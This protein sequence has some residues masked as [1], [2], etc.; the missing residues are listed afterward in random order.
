VKTR[1]YFTIEYVPEGPDDP[2][3]E[4]AVIE[5][6]D[7]SIEQSRPVHAEYDVSG[8]VTRLV[9]DPVTTTKIVGK[10]Y[11]DLKDPK[12]KPVE[13]HCGEDQV[14]VARVTGVESSPDDL[15]ITVSMVTLDST[16]LPGRHRE[17]PFRERGVPANGRGRLV[18]L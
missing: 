18:V 4:P 2:E 13:V 14:G 5:F 15:V 12:F 10:E 3:I 17:G 6:D 7:F 1:A 9:P 8:Q 16:S 11:E